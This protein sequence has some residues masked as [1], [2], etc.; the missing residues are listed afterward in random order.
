M[1][2]KKK[3]IKIAYGILSIADL[4]NCVIWSHD[5]FFFYFFFVNLLG[6]IDLGRMALLQNFSFWNIALTTYLTK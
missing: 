1:I 2:E 3:T 5:D 4:Q 6:R